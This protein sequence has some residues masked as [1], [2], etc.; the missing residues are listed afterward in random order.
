MQRAY[1]VNKHQSGSFARVKVM[2]AADFRNLDH[3]TERRKLDGSADGRIFFERQMRT[4]SFVVFE[5]ILQNPAQPGLMENNDVIQ[6][7][8]TDGAHQSFR[9]GILPR[10]SR[11]SQDFPNAHRFRR[12]TELLTVHAVAVAQQVTR[13]VVPGESLQKLTGCPFCCGVSGHREMNRTSAVLIENHKDEQE[14]ELN[15]WDN[16][17]ICRNQVLGVILEKGSPRLRGRFPVPDHV[18]GD[19]C[20]R[21]L[22]TEFQEF[23]MNAR[24]AP[25]RVSETHVPDEIPNFRRYRR[26]TFATPTLPSPIEAKS[27]AMPSDNRLRFDQ[28]QRRSPIV[29]QPREPNPQDS[30]SPGEEELTSGRKHSRSGYNLAVLLFFFLFLDNL[31]R[32]AE[33]QGWKGLWPCAGRLAVVVLFGMLSLVAPSV[34][35]SRIASGRNQEHA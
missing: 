12:L 26:A 3:L 16:E 34:Y 33:G 15:R 8:A 9:K 18:L 30:I 11:R 35:W 29:P 7:F 25:A 5:I 10:R 2:Q 24:S 23:P 19:C 4:A 31:L 32:R 21:H 14:L 13:G 6:A 22:N 28:E 1:T 20:L 27:L 17:E